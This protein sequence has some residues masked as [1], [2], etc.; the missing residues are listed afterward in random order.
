MNFG[1]VLFG[2]GTYSTLTGLPSITG[3]TTTGKIGINVPNPTNTLHIYSASANTSGVRMERLTSSSPSS[4]GK[5]IGVDATGNIIT[6]SGATSGV[7]SVTGTQVNNTD[8]A[9]PIIK[10]AILE[11]LNEGNGNGIRLFGKS[12]TNYG[13]IGLD[14]IDLSYSDDGLN[15]LGATGESSFAVGNYVKASGF[16]GVV[17]GNDIN[18]AGIGSFSNGLQLIEAGYTNS[19]FGVRHQVASLGCTVVGQAANIVSE[20][21]LDWNATPNKALFVVG[22]GTIQNADPTY[23]ALSRSDAL[24]ARFNGSV[25]APSLTVAAITNSV[26]PKV[27]VTKEYIDTII[28]YRVYTAQITQNG[29]AAPTVNILENTLGTTVTWIRNGVGEYFGNFGVQ[30]PTALQNKIYKS[31]ERTFEVYYTIG[32]DIDKIQVVTKNA[33][34]TQDGLLSFTSIEVRVYN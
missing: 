18:S 28:P 4:V 14:A 31:I 12:P 2:S 34:A 22:N 23:T 20:Q 17:F 33:G 27:L 32:A 25:E 1:G 3:Q 19:L 24:I 6:V 26:T 16:S 7:Q 29:T 9:N 10:D 13:N 15:N 30:I 21:I 8:P 11:R 5:A